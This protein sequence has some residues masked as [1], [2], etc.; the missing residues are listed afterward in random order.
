MTVYVG[1]CERGCHCCLLNQKVTSHNIWNLAVSG[2]SDGPYFDSNVNRITSCMVTCDNLE[3]SRIQCLFNF[4]TM[5]VTVTDY[6]ATVTN[7]N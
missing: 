2:V 7:A 6:Y 4:T 5:I 3:Q 1:I